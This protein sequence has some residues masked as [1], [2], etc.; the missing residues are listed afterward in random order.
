MGVNTQII[1]GFPGV[2]KSYAC[3]FNF[4]KCL[5]SDSSNFSWESE[6]VRHPDFPENY[7]KHIK[8]NQ[9]KAWTIMV[10]SHKVVREALE[11]HGIEYTLVYP[12]KSLKAEYLDRYRKRGNDEKFIKFIG[13]HWD[14]FIDEIEQDIF[15]KK[16][17]LGSGEYLGD[18]KFRIWGTLED[19]KEEE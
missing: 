11:A 15:P 9:G 2:G 12:D 1:S 3:T 6:G 19:R 14:V 17:K 18:A 7:M 10:S 4:F 8:E 16:I 5:D 13:D